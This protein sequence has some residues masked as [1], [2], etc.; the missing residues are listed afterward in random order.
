MVSDERRLQLNREFFGEQVEKQWH[1]YT[2]PQ[3]D[4]QDSVWRARVASARA[5]LG[6]LLEPGGSVL[7]VGC[8]TGPLSLALADAGFQVTAVDLIEGMLARARQTDSRVNWVHA[9]FSDK[10]AP[11]ASF[12]AVVALGF[13]E[14][15]ERAGKELVRMARLLKPGGHLLLSVPNTLSSQ[16][17]FGLTRALFRAGKEPERIRVRHSF[18][19]ERLQRLLGMAGYILMDYQWID[20]NSPPLALGVTRERPFWEHRVRDRFKPEM[21]TLSRTY[22]P[23]DTATAGD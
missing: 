1:A 13:L 14:Y 22:T 3:P 11:K 4:F 21:L 20:H 2:V 16:F 23:S 7:D 10:I 15:Q 6:S 8:G 17:Q 9:P 18:T 12:D 19:P 5:T